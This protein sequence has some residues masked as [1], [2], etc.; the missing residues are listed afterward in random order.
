MSP[1]ERP[2]TLPVGPL[3]IYVL[4]G[5]KN[6]KMI[7]KNTKTLSK[8]EAAWMILRNMGV[9]RED[10]D[11]F[12]S[13][14][15]GLAAQ[16]SDKA[17]AGTR[18]MKKTHDLGSKYLSNGHSVNILTSRFINHFI[19]ELDKEPLNHQYTTSLYDHFRK[20][21]FVGSTK[22]LVGTEFFSLCPDLA[23]CYWDFDGAFPKVGIGLPKILFSKQYAATE[24]MQ[25]YCKKWVNHAWENFDPDNEEADWEESFGSGFSRN[26]VKVLAE[27]GITRDG[28]ACAMIPIIWA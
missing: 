12:E 21:M 1:Q 20:A 25:E 4:F 5:P 2:V 3:R 23:D 24:R 22:A 19:D 26:M 10:M 11:I 16:S 7:F 18:V 17:A 8:M 14:H 13:D 6:I 28:Q 9:P 15:S 27:C